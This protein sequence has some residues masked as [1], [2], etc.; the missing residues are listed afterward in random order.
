[1]VAFGRPQE[2]RAALT[3]VAAWV[4]AGV[5][6]LFLLLASSQFVRSSGYG[7]DLTCYWG[8]AQRLASGSGLYLPQNLDGPFQHGAPAVYVYAPPLAVLLAPAT[9]LPFDVVALGWLALHLAALVLA[10][11]LMPVRV[12]IRLA[13]FAAAAFSSP[14]LVDLN[15]G[16]VSTFV[17]L[18]AVVGWRWLDRPHAAV[19]LAAG[20]AIRPQLAVLLIWWLLRRKL[21]LAAYT[22]ATGAVI[23][24]AT[25][26]FVGVQ[27]YLDFIRVVRND[28]V[29]G[30]VHNGSL[31]SAAMLLGLSGPVP[32]LAFFAGALV[33]IVAIV[34][35]LRR[36]AEV[37]YAVTACASL[38]LTPLLWGHYLLVLLIPAALLA[39]R[40]R[41]WAL[42][43]PL[44][45]WL[46]DGAISIAALA[47]VLVPLLVPTRPAVP[48]PARSGNLAPA[49][50]QVV[51]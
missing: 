5:A 30:V 13:V 34:A 36:D 20:M 28:Q 43:L 32:T 45:G 11:A 2:L 7:F 26:P 41:T 1:M 33:A 29:A 18:V 27:S 17:L 38:L 12:P 14:L 22:F 47:G 25:L 37:S 24:L 10:C 42:A 6:G 3:R 16:N 8:G 44:L 48:E 31:E 15:L 46:P 9:A 4:G 19:T 51:R 49:R 39:Q 40:G 23:V 21:R 35:S 50:A